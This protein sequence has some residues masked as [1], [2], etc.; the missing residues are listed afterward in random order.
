MTKSKYFKVGSKAIAKTEFSETFPNLDVGEIDGDKQT[1]NI[2]VSGFAQ[3]KDGDIF[4][5]IPGSLE[6]WQN[7]I[8]GSKYAGKLLTKE[9]VWPLMKEDPYL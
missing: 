9:Q 1:P 8:A 5:E 6:S 2:T 7:E 3:A 4:I